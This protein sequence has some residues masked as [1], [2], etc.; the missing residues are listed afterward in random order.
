[1]HRAHIIDAERQMPLED[2][3]RT[4]IIS[5]QIIENV[6]SMGVEHLFPVQT[7]VIPFVLRGSVVGQDIAVSAPTGSGKTLAYAMPIVHVRPP[8]PQNFRIRLPIFILSH[9][10]PF[11][12]SV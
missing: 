9:F 3:E 2:L 8:S 10:R 5:T 6:K 11:S 4:G 12:P 7:E 1:M